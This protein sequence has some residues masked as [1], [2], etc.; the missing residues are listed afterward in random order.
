MKAIGC[1]SCDSRTIVL[2]QREPARDPRKDFVIAS[3]YMP[4]ARTPSSTKQFGDQSRSCA[5]QLE[6]AVVAPEPD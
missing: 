2:L 5:V 6:T 1:A 3:R 4:M